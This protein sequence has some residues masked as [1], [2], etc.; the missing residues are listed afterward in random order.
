MLCKGLT[1]LLH[2]QIIIKKIKYYIYNNIRDSLYHKKTILV[3]DF[4]LFPKISKNPFFKKQY[5]RFRILNKYFSTLKTNVLI[6]KNI[7][8]LVLLRNEILYLK[9]H[10]KL[11]IKCKNLH[12]THKKYIYLIKTKGALEILRNKTKLELIDNYIDIFKIIFCCKQTI[13]G[14]L[15]EKVI[16]KYEQ[17]LTSTLSLKN[18]YEEMFKSLKMYNTSFLILKKDLENALTKSNNLSVNK[19]YD[20]LIVSKT[21]IENMLKSAINKV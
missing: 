9:N 3:N 12:K 11:L 15:D 21:K 4:I 14:A 16:L 10:K 6:L 19:N 13:L 17:I 7:L 18:N 8:I 5:L 2:S 1:P 20:E